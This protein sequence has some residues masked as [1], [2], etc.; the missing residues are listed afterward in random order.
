MLGICVVTDM[1]PA[2]SLAYENAELDIM[3]RP[4]RNAKRDHLVTAKMI[5]YSYLQIGM[6]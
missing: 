6:F 1:L 5:S 4:P 3:R 2:I